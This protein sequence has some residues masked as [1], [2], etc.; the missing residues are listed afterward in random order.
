MTSKPLLTIARFNDVRNLKSWLQS[1]PRSREFHY[2]NIDECLFA[3]YANEFFSK[4]K[5]VESISSG[6]TAV[7][8]RGA[9]WSF[10]RRIKFTG[11]ISRTNTFVSQIRG[12]FTVQQ[13]LNFLKK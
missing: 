6:G 12:D 11:K 3:S 1:Q 4:P 5:G 10:L 7:S 13:V 2:M 9:K 8:L